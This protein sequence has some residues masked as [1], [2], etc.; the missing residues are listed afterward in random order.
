MSRY[1][2]IPV[3]KTEDGTE[4]KQ[5]TVYVSPAASTQDYYVITTTGD[6]FDI[7]AKQFYGDSDLWWVIASANP[8]VRKDTLFIEP[9]LQLRI[10]GRSAVAEETFRKEN[11]ER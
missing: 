9:G 3:T 10:P 1:N 8:Q 7:L 11:R 5:T 4:Y 6:R 2:S